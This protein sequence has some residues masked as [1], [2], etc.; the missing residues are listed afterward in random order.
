VEDVPQARLIEN[1][2][3]DIRAELMYTV[4]A[5]DLRK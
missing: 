2:A 4:R 3:K 5:D 1:R